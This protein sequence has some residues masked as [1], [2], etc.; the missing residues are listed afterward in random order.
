MHVSLGPGLAP[1]HHDEELE[2]LAARG[3]EAA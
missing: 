1:A 3:A 2:E